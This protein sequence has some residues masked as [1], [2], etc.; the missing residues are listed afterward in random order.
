MNTDK[1]VNEPDQVGIPV[2]PEKDVFAEAKPTEEQ[3]E[4]FKKEKLGETLDLPQRNA[5]KKSYKRRKNPDDIFF[6]F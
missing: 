1:I 2:N 6:D 3:Q 4:A 5:I